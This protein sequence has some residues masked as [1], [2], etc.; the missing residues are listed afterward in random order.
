MMR[1]VVFY[2]GMSIA[3]LGAGLPLVLPSLPSS[4]QSG[5]LGPVGSFFINNQNWIVLFG[6]LL[7][8]VSI[9]L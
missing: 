5:P 2:T 9:F 7:A 3:V 4:L 6:L 1:G 8:L